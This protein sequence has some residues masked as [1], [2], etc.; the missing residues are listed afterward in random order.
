YH[1]GDAF[2]TFIAVG[3]NVTDGKMKAMNIFSGANIWEDSA[4]GADEKILCTGEYG[5]GNLY[6]GCK[7][8]GSGSSMFKKSTGGAFSDIGTFNSDAGIYQIVSYPD[9]NCMYLFTRNGGIYHVAN[10]GTTFTQKK[11][12]YP[13]STNLTFWSPYG[14]NG[15][16]AWLV[17]DRIYFILRESNLWKAQLWAYDIGDDAYIHIYTFGAGINPS[18]LIEFNGNLYLFD[19]NKNINRLQIWK[20]TVFTSSMERIHEIGRVGDTSTIKGNPVK[21][22]ESIY[23]VVDDGSS[24]YQIWQLDPNDNIFSGITPPAAFSSAVSMLGMS[25]QGNLAIFLNGASGTNLIDEYDAKPN[26]DR[27]T[28]GFITTNIFDA[29]IPAL[30]KL[31]YDAT[32]TFDVLVSGQT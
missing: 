8:V 9:G 20:Y 25:G 6:A 27:Q 2:G 16:A 12:S 32:I 10:G 29:D 22:G 18:K 28:T 1:Y 5:D 7:T 23:F 13:Y 24:D 4:T 19:T 17:G 14:Q 30:D 11:S 31:F 26:N 3:R 21:D 15:Q